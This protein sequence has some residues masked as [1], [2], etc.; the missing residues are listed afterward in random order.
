VLAYCCEVL[1]FVAQKENLAAMPL[2]VGFDLWDAVERGSLEIELHHHTQGLRE[3]GVHPDGKIESTDLALFNQPRERWHG[4]SKLLIRIL[5]RVI[6]LFLRAEDFLD[7]RV[8]V[9]ERKKD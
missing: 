4:L 1:V 9:E 7:F 8:V 2:G 5:C 6:A 3:S